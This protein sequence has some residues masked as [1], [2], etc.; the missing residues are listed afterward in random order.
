[1]TYSQLVS[2]LVH[3]EDV[4]RRFQR[5]AQEV[6]LQLIRSVASLLQCRPDAI[7]L[8]NMTAQDGERQVDEATVLTK[9]GMYCVFQVKFDSIG[10]NIPVLFVPTPDGPSAEIDG[11]RVDLQTGNFANAATH[12]AERVQHYVLRSGVEGPL[13]T[14]AEGRNEH[15]LL[16]VD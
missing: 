5:A 13:T 7:E 10:I 16:I 8:M 6:R 4:T 1:M 11:K 2:R 14:L 15:G 9:K 12:F 3:Q